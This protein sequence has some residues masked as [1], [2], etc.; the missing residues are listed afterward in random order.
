MTEAF[1]ITKEQ[2]Y[3]E[4]GYVIPETLETLRD[5]L[6]PEKVRRQRIKELEEVWGVDPKTLEEQGLK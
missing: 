5:K 3:E 4:T 2:I 1:R 6:M